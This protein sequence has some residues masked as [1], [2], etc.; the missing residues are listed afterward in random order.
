VK[1]TVLYEAHQEM[2][3]RLV[4]FGGWEMPL[5]YGSQI[6]EHHA[7]REAAGMFDVSH[8]QVV[9]IRGCEA[10]L[11]LRRLLANDV[12]RLTLPGK[13]LYSCMLNEDG[14]WSTISSST[15]STTPISGEIHYR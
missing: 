5:H 12:A 6:E 7:V 2:G 9:D 1:K 11:F 4:P 10:G 15:I 3:A 8:M 13:E 14:A